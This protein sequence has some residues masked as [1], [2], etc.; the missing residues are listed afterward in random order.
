MTTR[1]RALKV[2][3]TDRDQRATAENAYVLAVNERFGVDLSQFNTTFA[4]DEDVS[5]ET[6]LQKQIDTEEQSCQYNQSII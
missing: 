6:L 4:D 2:L 5:L 1:Y 3:L